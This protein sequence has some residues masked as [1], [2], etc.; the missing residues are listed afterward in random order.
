M[1]QVFVLGVLA[2][3][4]L[5][6]C[7][8]AAQTPADNA[9]AAACT[10]QGDALYQ[11]DTTNLQARTAQNGLMYGATPT[12]VFDGEQLGALNARNSQI[13]N[14]EQTGGNNGQPVVNGVPVIAPHI[15]AN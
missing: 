2:V 13:Q 14:C 4:G 7:A 3:C 15:I 10:S 6:G 9:E 5:A 1:K 8:P 12:H 11:Q